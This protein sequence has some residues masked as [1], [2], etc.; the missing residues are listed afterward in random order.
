LSLHAQ[1]RGNS[2]EPEAGNIVPGEPAAHDLRRF[3][4]CERASWL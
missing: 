1:I 2:C 4:I 3:R